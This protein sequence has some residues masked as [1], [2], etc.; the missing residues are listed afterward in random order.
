MKKL[1]MFL[2]I[3]FSLYQCKVTYGLDTLNL[4]ML[5]LNNG[6]VWVY[7]VRISGNS[8]GVKLKHSVIGDTI[9]AGSRLS[10]ISKQCAL[11][12]EGPLPRY[13]R[14]DTSRVSLFQY[15]NGSI[16]MF[17]SLQS[18]NGGL[19]KVCDFFIREC[20]SRG[21]TDLFGIHIS[22]VKFAS[23]NDYNQQRYYAFHLAYSYHM[24][25]LI[26]II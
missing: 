16:C 3:I 18:N 13:L 6:N 20:E 24:M 1:I 4:G 9:A 11:P 23:I 8:T 7:S 17:D 19:A 5:P 10:L 22:K 14:M 12:V 15:K 2:C 26:R 21:T 25:R